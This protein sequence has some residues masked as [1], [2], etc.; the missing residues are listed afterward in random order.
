MALAVAPNEAAYVPLGHREASEG[1][2]SGLFAAKLCSG[3]ISERDALEA[4]KP[5][6]EDH[7]VIKVGHDVKRDWLVLACR[8]IASG[9][10]TIRC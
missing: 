8:G 2:T 4:L 5:I 6:F 7:S 9:R 10:P 3:Q 1:E